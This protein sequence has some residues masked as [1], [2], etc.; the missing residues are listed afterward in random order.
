MGACVGGFRWSAPLISFY[1]C[2]NRFVRDLRGNNCFTRNGA[3]YL[4]EIENGFLMNRALK[5][6]MSSSKGKNTQ[7]H[8]QYSS[9]INSQ[10]NSIPFLMRSRFVVVFVPRQWVSEIFPKRYPYTENG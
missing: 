9:Q 7:I 2:L 8:E 6:L 5:N 1:L 10:L 4:S 3:N